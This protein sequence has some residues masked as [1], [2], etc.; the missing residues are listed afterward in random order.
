MGQQCAWAVQRVGGETR[1]LEGEGEGEPD[2]MESW[3]SGCMFL[4]FKEK[5]ETYLDTVYTD[6]TLRF[7]TALGSI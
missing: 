4:T 7:P 6:T 1:C 2:H 3:G 5:G